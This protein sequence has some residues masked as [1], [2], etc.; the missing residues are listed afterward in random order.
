MPGKGSPIRH[1]RVPDELWV[2]AR[3]K[4]EREGTSVSAVLV[5]CLR[6]W[7]GR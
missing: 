4:A 7:L 5:G 2:A 3:E 1:V 6:G